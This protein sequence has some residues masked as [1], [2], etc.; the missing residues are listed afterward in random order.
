MPV[1]PNPYR[2]VCPKCG[3]SKVVTLK[4]DV[5]SP[6]DLIAMSPVCS[7]CKEQMERKDLNKLDDIFSM[8]RK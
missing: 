7:K 6:K 4:S 3:F 2:L 1:K 5:L 8:F